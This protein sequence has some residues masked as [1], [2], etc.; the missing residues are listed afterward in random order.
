MG[1]CVTR[2]EAGEPGCIAEC[3]YELVPNYANRMEQNLSL[4]LS[5]A[6]SLS[7]E[8]SQKLSVEL[9]VELYLSL[10]LAISDSTG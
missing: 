10:S 4:S 3:F 2:R 5:V 6:L 7:L 8:L 1:E 9:S